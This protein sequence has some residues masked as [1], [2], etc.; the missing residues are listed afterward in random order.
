MAYKFQTSLSEFQ[1]NQG[2]TGRPCFKTTRFP[3]PPAKK[4]VGIEGRVWK[5]RMVLSREHEHNAFIHT[6]IY[7]YFAVKRQNGSAF[8]VLH[9]VSTH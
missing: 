5:I 1:A 4:P 9:H 3:P 8:I 7:V 2:Y 6:Y